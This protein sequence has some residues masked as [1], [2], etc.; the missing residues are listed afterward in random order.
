MQVRCVTIRECGF[1]YYNTRKCTHQLFQFR[2][3]RF[4]GQLRI[5]LC[6][7]HRFLK[8]ALERSRATLALD[9]DGAIALVDRALEQAVVDVRG[10]DQVVQVVPREARLVKLA[11]QMQQELAVLGHIEQLLLHF[12][13]ALAELERRI[14]Q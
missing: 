11:E 4:G 9:E 2:F 6:D 5:R 3:I 7:A 1:N 12:A 8:T 14:G 13:N 10:L